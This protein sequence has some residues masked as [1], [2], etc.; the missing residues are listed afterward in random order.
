M[1]IDQIMT[2]NVC[3]CRHDDSLERAGAV[4]VGSRLRVPPGLHL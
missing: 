3:T 4:H 2:R 1:R